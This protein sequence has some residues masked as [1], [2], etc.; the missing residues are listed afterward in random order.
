M[1]G[2]SPPQA[3]RGKDVVFV[4]NSGYLRFVPAVQSLEESSEDLWF[5]FRGG[6]LLTTGGDSDRRVPRRSEMLSLLELLTDKI[7]LGTLDGKGCLAAELNGS[8]GLTPGFEAIDL[9]KLLDSLDET[10]FLAAGR[11]AQLLAWRRNTRY[12]GRCGKLTEEKRGERARICTACGLSFFP[13]LSP[14]VIVAVVRDRSILLARGKNSTLPFW[15]VLAGFVEPGESLEQCV[16]REVFEEVRLAV[17]NIRYFASQPWPFPDSFMIAFTAEYE[18]GDIHIDN[19]ELEAA[20]W[21][22]VQSLPQ[23]PRKGSVSRRLI[24]WF[25]NTYG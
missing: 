4:N 20:A 8:A 5:V 11:A 23:V 12:C 17:K 22:T 6:S 3:R 1:G 9:R 25:A 10:T 14:A 15:S 24:D 13:R 21:Y 2:T 18:S 16:R 19:M 7:Y